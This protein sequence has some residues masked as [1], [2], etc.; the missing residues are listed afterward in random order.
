VAFE[1]LSHCFAQKNYKKLQKIFN[2]RNQGWV[3]KNLYCKICL[4]NHAMHIGDKMGHI[5]IEFE[6]SLQF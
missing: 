6:L 3:R 5:V 2:A 4:L 1:I